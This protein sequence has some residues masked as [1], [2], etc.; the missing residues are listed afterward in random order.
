MP[1]QEVENRGSLRICR[2]RLAQLGISRNTAF[3]R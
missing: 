3:Y 2:G 1:S